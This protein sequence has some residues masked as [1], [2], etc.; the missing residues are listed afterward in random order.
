[1]KENVKN[2]KFIIEQNLRRIIKSRFNISPMVHRHFEGVSG[3]GFVRPDR[4][5]ERAECSSERPA[6]GQA[7]WHCAASRRGL[8]P[9]HQ[10]ST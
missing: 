9:G 2:I 8:N 1:M 7:M 10:P 5:E 4:A 6:G 3:S